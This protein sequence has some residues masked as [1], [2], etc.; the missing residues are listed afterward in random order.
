MYVS[1]PVCVCVCARERAC[2]FHLTSNLDETLKCLS[3][4]IFSFFF[5]FFDDKFWSVDSDTVLLLLVSLK[6]CTLLTRH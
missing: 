4:F 6:Y 3:F 1:V 5:F 2:V